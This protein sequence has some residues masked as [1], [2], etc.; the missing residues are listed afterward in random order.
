MEG[1]FIMLI[2]GTEH[3]RIERTKEKNEWI[4]NTSY[5]DDHLDI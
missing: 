4:L 3:L 1:H 2:L 5:I